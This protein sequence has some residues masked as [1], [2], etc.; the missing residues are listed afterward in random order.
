[1]ASVFMTGFPGFIG[2]QLVQR[3]L[4]RCPEDVS[5][6]CLIQPAYRPQAEAR[7]TDIV[8]EVGC[9]RT[10]LQ[11]LEGDITQPDLGLGDRYAALLEDTSEVYHLAAVYD[12]G[13]KR[14]FAMRINVDG[15]RNVLNFASSCSNLEHF[16]YVS[17][18]Y[19]SGRHA[20]R[21][22]EEALDCGQV[23]NNYYEE[24][25]F[26]A[27]VEVQQRMV[28]GLPATIYRPAIVA[29][30]SQTGATQ[31]FDGIYYMLRWLLRQPR[32]LA[33]V[34]KVGDPKQYEVN[35]AP[36]NF[37]V[38][39]INYLSAQAGSVG[40][41][42][43]LCDPHAPKVDQMWKILAKAV[44]RTI[45][46]LPLS[47]ELVRWSLEKVW[48]IKA[49]MKIEPAAVDY[50]TT[51]PTFYTCENTLKDLAGTGIACPPI[52]SYIKTL[53]SFMLAHPDISPRA[54]V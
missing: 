6:N 43:Q 9:P 34:P 23:F 18:C 20:G 22:S 10:R 54:M 3:R 11:L 12:L 39:A 46:P 19:V 25:K 24:T 1:M 47:R 37:V 28:D 44:Q 40:K 50:V 2:S 7:V 31:K 14:E 48:P 5:I 42:Y 36:R 15:T 4:E 30:D 26:L 21:F 49:Y 17:T 16:Q 35:V 45:L 27:E 51:H 38:D 32:F 8:Q 33:L 29:G 13:V 53:V 41:V 52:E